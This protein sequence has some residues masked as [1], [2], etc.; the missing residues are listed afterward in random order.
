MAGFEFVSSGESHGKR[1]AWNV[2][3]SIILIQKLWDW[4]TERKQTG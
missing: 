4:Q 1:L 2:A 3:S